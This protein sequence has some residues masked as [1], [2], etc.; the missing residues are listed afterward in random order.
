MLV[1]GSPL[2]F[3]YLPG[4]YM[5]LCFPNPSTNTKLLSKPRQKVLL[6]IRAYIDSSQMLASRCFKH[7]AVS[8][9]YDDTHLFHFLAENCAAADTQV[10]S[11]CTGPATNMSR[12]L[13]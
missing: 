9:N 6:Q 12:W 8:S 10:N 11:P 4:G 5:F 3:I 13:I 2:S 1:D 7:N